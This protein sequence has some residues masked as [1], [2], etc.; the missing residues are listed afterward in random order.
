MLTEVLPSVLVRSCKTVMLATNASSQ[1]TCLLIN[2]P[3]ATSCAKFVVKV[4]KISH[5][6]FWV[7]TLCGLVGRCQ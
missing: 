7:V 1:V 5:L 6:V 4:V 2:R 3:F